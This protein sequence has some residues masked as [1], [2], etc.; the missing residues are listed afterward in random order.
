MSRRNAKSSVQRR[1]MDSARC[2]TIIK[3]E[4]ILRKKFQLKYAS[5]SDFETVQTQW[6]QSTKFDW[7]EI[8]KRWSREVGAFILAIWADHELCAFAL[9]TKTSSY[10]TIQF[11]ERKE[12]KCSLTG[13]ILVIIL[14]TAARYA[15][16]SGAGELR[17][18]PKNDKLVELYVNQYGFKAEK[19]SK[20]ILYCY[21]KV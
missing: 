3:L 14:E 6:E 21:M 9:L 19:N 13:N 12:G 20:G 17:L 18:E 1:H 15:Q 16:L 11:V 7:E 5:R 8:H 2:G 4:P 10:V